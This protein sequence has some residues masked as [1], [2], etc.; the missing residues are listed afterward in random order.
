MDAR[1]NAT[2][3]TSEPLKQYSLNTTD[4][5]AIG[6][7]R[8]MHDGDLLVDTPYQRGDVWTLDQR[9][10]LIKSFLMGLPVPALVINNR[11]TLVWERN[12]PEP[13]VS[14]AVID[15]KQ[16]ILAMVAWYADDFAVPASWFPA[17]QVETVE[18]TDD[19]PYVRY[20]GLTIVGQRFF[21]RKSR[22]PV[23]EAAVGTIAEEAEIY[24]L[25]NGG[26][27]GQTAEDMARA[28]RVALHPE[29]I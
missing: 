6:M 14:Y 2:R 10:A 27:T 20:S 12:N 13:D 4:R 24:L 7:A 19:G 23:C 22:F 25:V 17:K 8:L 11:M 18:E 16:R 29:G 5:E 26:G 28:A 3:Q 9:I 1:A 21:M 15:G